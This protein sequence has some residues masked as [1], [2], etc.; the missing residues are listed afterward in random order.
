MIHLEEMK[1]DVLKKLDY[2]VYNS[3]F[4]NHAISIHFRLGDYKKVQHVHPIMNVKYYEDSLQYIQE[5]RVA[6]KN[7]LYFCEE[8]DITEVSQIIDSLKVKFPKYQFI[9]ADNELE[10]WEQMLLMS[11]CRYNIIANSTFSWWGAYFNSDSKKMVIYPSVWFGP[12]VKYV[13][14]DLFPNEWIKMEVVID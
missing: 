1:T 13:T 4:F 2:N 14:D 11:C 3:Y 5:R 9:R 12:N 10:D 6:D 7:V 8:E